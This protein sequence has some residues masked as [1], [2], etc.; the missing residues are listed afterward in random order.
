MVPPPIGVHL[1]KLRDNEH[2]VVGVRKSWP[3]LVVVAEAG[4]PI[5]EIRKEN[6]D[7]RRDC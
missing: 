4:D 5:V 2:E 7:S 1:K 3:W 6:H